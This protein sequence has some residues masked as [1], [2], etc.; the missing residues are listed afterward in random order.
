MRGLKE[1]GI[2]VASARWLKTRVRSRFPM[3][4]YYT[5]RHVLSRVSRAS[6]F[7]SLETA[8]SAGVVSTFEA[9]PRSESAWP[10]KAP[11]P[12]STSVMPR[13]IE[14]IT[15]SSIPTPLPNQARVTPAVAVAHL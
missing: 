15:E 5:F 14:V 11:E 9:L 13:A 4:G 12:T 3:S 8:D 7:W 6:V 1:S 2:V 10:N